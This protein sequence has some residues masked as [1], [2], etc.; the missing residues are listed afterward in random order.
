MIP[1]GLGNEEFG[2]GR[3]SFFGEVLP[4]KAQELADVFPDHRMYRTLRE[5]IDGACGPL[6]KHLP[7]LTATFTDFDVAEALG[8]TGAI[9]VAEQVVRVL[10][11]NRPDANRV[12]FICY[13]SNGDVVRHHPDRKKA[14]RPQKNA[15]YATSLPAPRQSVLPHGRCCAA[16]CGPISARTASSMA[17][18]SSAWECW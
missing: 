1:P 16:G 18:R 4:R 9:V 14:Q 5:A 12:D 13:R 3:L 7:L 8:E 17:W 6:Y 15:K 10:D 11:V 2:W